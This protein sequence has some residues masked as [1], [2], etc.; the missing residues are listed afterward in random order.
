[1]GAHVGRR[2]EKAIAQSFASVP[3]ARV[4]NKNAPTSDLVFGLRLLRNRS[5]TAVSIG[6]NARSGW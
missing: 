5:G 6:G 4:V 1:M 3:P 2:D